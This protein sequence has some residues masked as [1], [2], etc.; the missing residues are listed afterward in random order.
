MKPGFTTTSRKPRKRARNGA[1]PPHQNRKKFHTQPSAGKVILT[2]F[3]DEWGVILE[4]FMPRG[5][6][7]TSVTYADLLK[8]HLRPAI[9]VQTTWKSEYR[10]F[11]PTWKCSA[12]YYPFNHCNNPRSVLGETSTST[13][14]AR[15]CPQWLSCLW[16]TQR[17]DRRQVFQVRRRGAAGGARVAALSA[18]RI[19]F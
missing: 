17:G 9:Q 8:N 5:N 18:K 12:S 16:T 10:C 6:T 4:H 13:I 19:F 11:A 1:I 3:W 14:L 2:L 7:V 15:P